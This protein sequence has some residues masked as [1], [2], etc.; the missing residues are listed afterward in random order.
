V[1]LKRVSGV[2]EKRVDDSRAV[3]V[4]RTK[5]CM[6]MQISYMKESRAHSMTE[7]ES[8]SHVDGIV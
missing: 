7:P 6:S 8:S 5:T 3:G 1:R 4:Q 2:G